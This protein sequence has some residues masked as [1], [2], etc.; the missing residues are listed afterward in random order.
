MLPEFAKW[1]SI[2]RLSSEIC[3]ITEKIDGTNGVIHVSDDG[4]VLSGSRE[5]WLS[6]EDGTPC[7]KESDNFGFSQWVYDRR[8]DL[9]RLGVGYHYGEFHGAGIQRNYG[10]TDKRWACF[11][12]WR[13]DIKIPDVCVVPILHQGSPDCTLDGTPCQW[14]DIWVAKLRGEGS[15]LY[16]GFMKP[17]GVVITFKEMKSCKFKR[18]CENDKIRK[19]QRSAPNAKT[20]G[21]TADTASTPCVGG[22]AASPC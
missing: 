4:I 6:K 16:P 19:L 22:S 14:W 11:E 2:Q 20:S 15:V 9:V 8:H 7:D 21:P 18:L 1:P 17:E 3:Y 12:Y 10:L 5:R 13:D